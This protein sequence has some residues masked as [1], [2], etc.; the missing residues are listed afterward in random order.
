MII[1][2]SQLYR[3]L[4]REFRIGLDI[5]I[6]TEDVIKYYSDWMPQEYLTGK[7]KRILKRIRKMLNK[8]FDSYEVQN[9]AAISAQHYARIIENT[10][11][12]LL[13]P[14]KKYARKV[15]REKDVVTLEEKIGKSQAELFVTF[16]KELADFKEYYMKKPD[17]NYNPQNIS[18][19]YC[20]QQDTD[21]LR[22]IDSLVSNTQVK[23]RVYKQMTE[24]LYEKYI[25]YLLVTVQSFENL[26]KPYEEDK[27]SLVRYFIELSCEN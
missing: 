15:G 16:N 23:L 27:Q 11:M 24:Y 4:N 13:A 8:H 12:P 14:L 5:K 21:V 9:I 19:Q 2:E 17:I 7:R 1:L 26:E 10:L 18:G 6:E 25:S 20:W 3:K 22:A